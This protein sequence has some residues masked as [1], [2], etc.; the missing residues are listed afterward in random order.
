MQR[1]GRKVRTSL[2]DKATEGTQGRKK[3]GQ[4]IKAVRMELSYLE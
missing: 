1:G 3:E 2:K 4:Q